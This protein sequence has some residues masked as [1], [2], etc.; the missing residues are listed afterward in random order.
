[1]INFLDSKNNFTSI[2]E[3]DNSIALV[4][5]LTTWYAFDKSQGPTPFI[6]NGSNTAYGYL[7][8]STTSTLSINL[9]GR[10]TISQKN[11]AQ[12]LFDYSYS[13]QL[14]QNI[15]DSSSQSTT[16]TVKLYHNLG[17]LIATSS[18]DNLVNNSDCSVA[19][20]GTITTK[21]SASTEPNAPQPLPALSSYVN[22]T[23]SLTFSSP[24]GTATYVDITG[25]SSTVQVSSLPF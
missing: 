6:S 3:Q 24:C 5:D 25:K 7:F 13:G 11:P 20:S 23:E 2:T 10:Y 12:I 14:T 16:G 22:A 21:F 17:H 15:S 18:L 8:N 9:A 4:L 1:L 19:T